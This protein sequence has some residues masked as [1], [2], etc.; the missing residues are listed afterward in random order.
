MLLRCLRQRVLYRRQPR[1]L[2]LEPVVH[3]LQLI[4]LHEEDA[5]DL[6]QRG[7]HRL[8]SGVLHHEGR[9]HRVPL[10]NYRVGE[11]DARCDRL[12][13]DSDTLRKG[14]PLLAHDAVG[15]D[16]ESSLSLADGATPFFPSR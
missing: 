3:L 6:E 9:R 5:G 7:G 16:A 11:K 12:S 10:S 1:E 14:G 2:L 8:E 13:E 15:K 4:L